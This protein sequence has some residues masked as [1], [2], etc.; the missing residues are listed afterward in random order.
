MWKKFIILAFFSNGFCLLAVNALI[1]LGMGNFFL[2]YLLVFYFVGFL[3]SF[4]FCFKSRTFPDK[5]ETIIGVVAGVSSFL[6]SLFMTLALT[7][8]PATIVFPIAGGG[9]LITVSVLAVLIFKEKLGIRGILG[10]ISG[11]IGLI[12]ISI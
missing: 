12:L 9:N 1:K 4:L 6:G 7:K 5:K 10:I 11:T 3:W 8:I 2:C